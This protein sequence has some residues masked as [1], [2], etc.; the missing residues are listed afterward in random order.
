[1]EKLTDA[2]RRYPSTLLCSLY[3][4][5][6]QILRIVNLITFSLSCFLLDEFDRWDAKG[7]K[8]HSKIIFD[9]L[10]DL[11]REMAAKYLQQVGNDDIT[12][13]LQY[14]VSLSFKGFFYIVCN[15]AC[16]VH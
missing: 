10:D 14:I 2:V 1:M 9:V 11:V 16:F 8:G 4:S 15:L 7:L 12:A 3:R 6:R 5:V 13:S